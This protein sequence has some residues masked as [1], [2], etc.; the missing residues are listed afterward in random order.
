MAT[1][2]ELMAALRK[3]DAAGDVEA[4][5]AIAKQAKSIK[6][7]SMATPSITAPVGDQSTP[8]LPADPQG[9]SGFTAQ[10]AALMGPPV[11]QTAV[12]PVI[13]APAM[14]AQVPQWIEEAV[15][16]PPAAAAPVAPPPAPVA[17]NPMDMIQTA[18]GLQPARGQTPQQVPEWIKQAQANPPPANQTPLGEGF[19][20]LAKRRGQQFAVGAAEVGASVPESLAILGAQ[21]DAGRVKGAADTGA[22]RATMIAEMQAAL[23]DPAIPQDQKA[24][25]ARNLADLTQG[26]G[27][28]AGMAAEPVIPAKDR[29]LFKAGDTARKAVTD[30]V[31][32]PDPR[33]TGFWSQVAQGAGNMT[34]MIG[35]AAVGGVVGGPAGAL[36]TGAASGSSLNAPSLYKEAL[37][38]GADEET[39]QRAASWGALIGASEIVPITRALKL[40]PPR[41]RGELTTGMMRKFVDIA[42]SSGE[43]AAQEYLATVANNIVAQQLFD[44]DR[45]WT[46]GATEAALVGAVLG[47]GV[48]A[49]GTA[50]EGKSQ[51]PGDPNANPPM[52]N[53][54]ASQ[55]PAPPMDQIAAAMQPPAPDQAPTAPQPAQPGPQTQQTQ[56]PTDPL[57]QITAAMTGQPAPQSGQSGQNGQTITRAE[58][59]ADPD[60]FEIVDE[61]EGQGANWRPTGAQVV[62]DKTTGRA[63][64]LAPDTAAAPP[65]ANAAT[66]ISPDGFKLVHGG[67]SGLTLDAIEIIRT[68]QKQAKNGKKLGGF[69][70]ASEADADYAESYAGMVDG[71]TTYDVVIKPGTKILRKDGDITRLSEKQI[72][73]WLSQGIGIVVGKDPRGKTEYAVIDK[74]AIQSLDLRRLPSPPS[75]SGTSQ[76]NDRGN[77]ATGEA[78]EADVVAASGGVTPPAPNAAPRQK[79]Q[80]ERRFLTNEETL[81]IQTD[82]K[83]FQ[84]KGGGDEAGVTDRLRGVSKFDPVRAGQVILFRKADGSLTVADGHQRTG[85]AKRAAEAGQADVGGMAAVIYDEADGYTPEK[86]MVIA[87]L[88]NIG[89]GSGTALDAA[90]ILRNTEETV[91]DLGL[92]PRSAL[93]RDADGLLRLSPTAFGMV[94]NGKASERDGAVV[95]RVVQDQAVQADILALLTRINPPNAAQAEMIARDAAADTATETQD[96]LFG[97]EQV[98][99][100]LYVERAKI[101]DGAVKE[102]RKNKA[103]FNVLLKNGTKIEG[104]GNKLDQDANAAQVQQDAMVLEYVQRQ[105]NM[106]GPISEALTAAARAVKAGQSVADAR[107]AF[108]QDVI[109]GLEGGGAGSQAAPVGGGQAAN[110]TEIP[111]TE[112]VTQG[113]EAQ[114]PQG[115]TRDENAADGDLFG[116][117]A[118]AK[119]DPQADILAAMTG[120]AAKPDADLFGA[121][122]QTGKTPEQIRAEAEAKVRADQSKLRKPDGNTGD[123]GPLFGAQ[124]DLLGSQGDKDSGQQEEMSPDTGK[125]PTTLEAI[126]AKERKQREGQRLSFIYAEYRGQRFYLATVGGNADNAAQWW[127]TTYPDASIFVVDRAD[128]TSINGDIG[129]LDAAIEANRPREEDTRESFLARIVEAREKHRGSDP[130]R[131]SGFDDL[132]ETQRGYA[133]IEDLAKAKGFSERKAIADA[134]VHERGKAT[135]IEHMV[136][137]DADG[138]PLLIASGAKDE[139]AFPWYVA[140]MGQ[141]GEIHYLTHNHPSSRGASLADVRSLFRFKWNAFGVMAANGMRYEVARGPMG[142]DLSLPSGVDTPVFDDLYNAASNELTKVLRARIIPVRREDVEGNA[143]EDAKAKRMNG[144]FDAI[145]NLVYDRLGILSVTGDIR[146]KALEGTDGES[147]LDEIISTIAQRLPDDRIGRAGFDVATIRALEQDRGV[148]ANAKNAASADGAGTNGTGAGTGN[149]SRGDRGPNSG[150]IPMGPPPVKGPAKTGNADLDGAL[151][152][153]FG[154]ESDVSGTGSDLER[155]SGDGATADGVG[156]TDVPASSGRSGRGTGRRGK[157]ADGGKRQRRPD[158]GLPDGDAPAVGAGSNQA[159]DGSGGADSQPAASGNGG[160]RDGNRNGRLPADGAGKGNAAGNATGTAPK[161]TPAERLAAIRNI[162]KEDVLD[163]VSNPYML[164]E[165]P[166]NPI[167]PQ[168]AD[169]LASIFIDALDG[170]DVVNATD[171][172]LFRAIIMPLAAPEVG[173]TRA[174]VAELTPYLEAFLGDLRA[175]RINLDPETTPAP[176]A[177]EADDRA[178]MQAEADKVRVKPTD[179]ANIDATLPL[180]LPEQRDDVF[181]VETRFAKPDGHGMMITN[182]TGTGK[183]FSGGGVIKRFYQGGKKNILIIAP[184]DAVIAGWT[185]ALDALAVPVSQLAGTKDAGQGVVI[186]TYA[187]LRANDTLASRDWDLVVTDE[188]QNLMSNADGGATGY[189]QNLRAITKRPQDFWHLVRMK[190]ADEI[191]KLWP[192]SEANVTRRASPAVEAARRALDDKMRAETQAM[193]R[194]P[195]PRSKVL[196]L[197]ATPFAYDK[198]VDYAEGYLFNYPEDGRINGSNQSGRNLFMVQNFGYRIRYHKLTKPEHAVDSAVFER[199][200]HEKLKREGVLSGR[201]LQVDVDYDRKF[202][203]KE[204]A[205]GTRLDEALEALDELAAKEREAQSANTKAGNVGT[206]LPEPFGAL[207]NHMRKNFDYL[208][209]QQLLEAIKARL[210]VDEIKAHLALGRKVVVFHDFNV[211]GGLNPFTHLKTQ[212]V[213]IDEATGEEIRQPISPMTAEASEGYRKLLEAH[214]WIRDLNFAGY[215]PPI[216]HLPEALGKTVRLFNGNVPTKQRLA[217]LADFNTDGSGVDV[218]VVQADAGGAGI[219]MHDVTKGHQ[220][221]LINL[222]MP[223]KPTTTLQQEGRILRVGSMSDAI[224]RYFTIGTGWERTAFAQRIAERSGTVENLALGNDARDM[225]NAFIDAYMDASDFAPSAQDGKGGKAKDSRTHTTTP[226]QRAVSHYFGRPR[227]TG[228]RNQRDGIDFYPTAE[229]LAFKM[230]EWAGIRANERVLEP[231]AGDGAIVRYMP[232]DAALTFVEPSADLRSTAQLRAPKGDAKETTFEQ[233]HIS[234]KYHAIVMN[235]PFGSGGSTAIQHLAKAAKHLRA[236]G[237]IVALIPTGPAADRKFAT[238]WESDDAKGLNLSAEV[239][240]PAVAFERAGTGV[241]TRVVIIDKPAEGQVIPM[242]QQNLNFTGATT[243]QQFFDRLESYEVRRRPDPVQDVIEE[244]EAEGQDAEAPASARRPGPP[245]AT[246]IG[247]FEKTTVTSKKGKVFPAAHHAA[248]VE[249]DVYDQMKAAATALDGW[250]H[251]NDA[252]PKG[253]GPTFAFRTEAARDA[254]LAEMQKPTALGGMEETPSDTFITSFMSELAQVDDLFQNPISK[255]TTIKGTLADIDPSIRFSGVLAADDPRVEGKD[256]DKVTL[257]YT[258]KDKPFYVY[259]TRGEVWIDVSDLGKG[260]GGSRIYSAISDYALNVGKVFIGDPEGLSVTALRRRT[261]NMLSTALKHGT[262]KHIAPHQDQITGNR[263]LGVPPLRWTEADDVGNVE[264][265]IDVSVANLINLVPEVADARY[266]FD[267]GTFR[268]GEGQPVTDETVAGWAFESERSGT[269]SVGAA[270]VKRG[271]LLNTLSRTES[272]QRPQL[273]ERALRQQRRL[274]TQGGLAR[275]FYQTPPQLVREAAATTEE[276]TRLMPALRAELDRLDLKRVKLS[277]VEDGNGWQGAFVVTGDGEMEIVIGASLNPIKTLHHEVIHALRAMNLFTGAEWQALTLA[278]ERKWLAKHDIAA[279]YPHLTEAERIEEAIAEEF[280]EALAAKQAPKGSILI[281]AFNKIAR[282]FRALRNVLNGAGYQ[283]PEDIFGRVLA[284]EVSAR[285]AGN[286]GAQVSFQRKGR[287]TDTGDLFAQPEPAKPSGMTA[288]QRREL[289]ARQKQSKMRKTGGNS[290]DAGPLFNDDKDLFGQRTMF[291]RQPLAVRPLTPQARAHRNSAMGATPFIPDRR[292]WE[293]LTR[294]GIPIWQR[295]RDLPGAA[296]DAVDRARYTIQ[297]RMLPFLRA[298]EA[299][300]MQTGR[301]LPKEHDAYLQETTFSGKVGRHLLEIDEEYTKPIIQ[302]IAKSKGKITADSV[303]EWLYARHAIERNAYIAS[304]NPNMPDGGSGMESIDAAQILADVASSPEAAQYDQIGA[305]IDALRERNLKLREDAGLISNADA[306]LWRTQYKH[307]VPLKGF[308]E[309]DHYESMMDLGGVRTGRRFS[310]RGQESKRALG[311]Q[312]EAFNP[313]Q[314]AITQAQEVAIRSEKNRVAQAMFE[315]AAAHPSKALWEVKRPKQ[316]RYFNRT[317]GLVEM[318]VENPVTMV[319][320]PNE[321]AVKIDGKEHRILFNDQRLAE[322]AGTLGADQMGGALRVLSIFSRFFSMTRTMLNPEFM[323]TNAFRDFQTAQFNIQ[324]FGE[325][326][327][328]RIAKAMAKNW[329]KAF[330]GAMRGSTY[331]FDTEWSRYY[332][333]FQKAGAQVWFWTMEQPEAARGDLEKRIGLARGNKAQRALKVMATPSAFFSFRDNAALSLIER[334]NLAVDNAIRLAAFVEARRAGWDVEKAAFLAKELTVNF[335]RRGEAGAQMNALYPFFNAAIQGSVRTAKALSSRRVAMMV[336]MSFVAGTMLDLLNAALSEEDDDGELLYDKVPNF[337]NERNLHFF[338]WGTGDNPFSAP[339]PYGYNV[340][341]YAGQQLGKVLRG[342]KDS[343]EAFGD[344]VK[345]AFG[346]FS[347]ISA[348]TP[349]QMISPVLSD[350]IVEMAENKNWLGIPIYPQDYGNQ[351]EPDAFVHFKGATEVSK[352]VAQSLND[353]TGGDFRESGAVDV[354]P[355]TLDHLSTFV[356]GSAG[357]FWGRSADFLAK[358]AKRDFD[359]IEQRNVPFVRV[360]TSPVGDWQDRDRFYRFSAEVKNAQSD[361]KAYEAAGQPVPKK[362]ANLAALYPAYLAAAREMSGKGEWNPAKVG[363]IAASAQSKVWLDFNGKYIRAMGKQGE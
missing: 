77:Q 85:L 321:M 263:K 134:W 42:Q 348:A 70:A 48:G 187:N 51:P 164:R 339:M 287:D 213:G 97:T 185:L 289:E 15:A 133:L 344:V 351:T 317:T 32:K 63:I 225:M 81:S 154:D 125:F 259:E 247:S 172:E 220:R 160:R 292:V 276:V 159:P 330:L 57:A 108:V 222:G 27:V 226:F 258:S 130:V 139:V 86:V 174:E 148:A 184:S 145:I 52:P 302:I 362:T 256:A 355:E 284:G 183:T 212:V 150:L 313:L 26:Q 138:R 353:L 269:P 96:D 128:G 92:P 224:F 131:V 242:G 67:K 354:S 334:T 309:T 290:G 62:I 297:D 264:S 44:A 16:N 102:L 356:T 209:R 265:L 285:H 19:G 107:R 293:S 257:L 72:A 59:E 299:V 245:L 36:V 352:W 155:D 310:I 78:P 4:A 278:A 182:G 45:G 239:Q 253:S 141:A 267:A 6:G 237:R 328:A 103:A 249:R 234:N 186:T 271:I 228:N 105:A 236:G 363:S 270:T 188:A 156:G 31:G 91:E 8:S 39:A 143:R 76:P 230:V 329:R 361:K 20:D 251:R 33:D 335:N 341:P 166:A 30:A 190:H 260:D 87:A 79:G 282:I 357:A 273:L 280:S 219:S 250:W 25:I 95:G 3:A 94:A 99:Q 241:M 13:K 255:A 181:K 60:R 151:D 168:K 142:Q 227:I 114:P 346:A 248:K 124:G 119:P 153:I 286:T 171:R 147:D 61:A 244:L 306:N 358:V 80:P 82:A 261:D 24:F 47:G 314:S 152:D 217:N 175:G 203:K 347:P 2:E 262:T 327:K 301:P 319:L 210:A 170:V 296:S 127:K 173:M 58:A 307:Y 198:T 207:Q 291:Q 359:A 11:Q 34:G 229:P 40:L 12:G 193:H 144:A 100:S 55:P 208:A 311:R 243:I 126:T 274:V 106:K 189:L 277:R 69:Y 326:D 211:G 112:Q 279:R 89:E 117:P 254:F 1:Y 300:M 338:L 350:P 146:T 17:A 163:F 331:R 343:D 113:G 305:M 252:A 360:L 74:N 316:K 93:V 90:R 136:A 118:P 22:Q 320:E 88:K 191:A 268:T 161:L 104:A 101:L 332:R 14:P 235:P 54:P 322:S 221:A 123:S 28:I 46:E 179:R 29:P 68:G 202:V 109:R 167:D 132:S 318:R 223:T 194:N 23:A 323:I 281:Q 5:K 37:E 288:D 246:E 333:E 275:T 215:K 196:F 345:A 342:V 18:M 140:R 169:A 137:L 158:S 121:T 73:D 206:R 283:T 162:L 240:L 178:A 340:F 308:E 10:I 64:P 38:A 116:G 43:E 53:P 177:I 266:D 298:Q 349:A 295:L 201:S 149:G 165:D 324:A 232:D 110:Q 66:E 21:A 312:S 135:K 337:R 325:A 71:G 157:A 9:P 84:Y 56:Q 336:A 195:P 238:W 65:P 35:A 180:L 218:L 197:S 192:K 49:I 231:S 304:I 41:V 199:D 129:D 111:A 83:A 176:P 272:G 7:I 216:K 98:A 204:D 294:A 50:L 303:G 214:P 315:L 200:F 75:S 115:E 122:P 205:D 120:Q 233:H